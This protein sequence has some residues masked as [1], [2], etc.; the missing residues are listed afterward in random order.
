[1]SLAVNVDASK[2][3]NTVF[4]QFSRNAEERENVISSDEVE[5][6]SPKG[7]TEKDL[8]E[9]EILLSKEMSPEKT[10]HAMRIFRGFRE[11]ATGKEKE[12]ALVYFPILIIYISV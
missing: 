8:K 7:I 9:L 10:Q 5:S 4:E 12:A 3:N 11:G 1:M 6:T 2:I